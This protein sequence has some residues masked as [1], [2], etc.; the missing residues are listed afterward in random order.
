M[1]LVNYTE[2]ALLASFV[3]L[4]TKQVNMSVLSKES[5]TPC[6]TQP[7]EQ[8][9]CLC[10]CMC[11]CAHVQVCCMCVCAGMHLLASYMP[12]QSLMTNQYNLIAGR[13]GLIGLRQLRT[14]C[15]V[16]S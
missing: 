4:T 5:R 12:S 7:S 8:R 2:R 9:S 16:C 10:V 13:F 11:V 1:L 15:L 14:N 6:T 3:K